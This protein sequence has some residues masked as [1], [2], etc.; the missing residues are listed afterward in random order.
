M[1]RIALVTAAAAAALTAAFALPQ[2]EAAAAAAPCFRSSQVANTRPDGDQTLYV[3]A[4]GNRYFRLDMKEPCNGLDGSLG[5]LVIEP[6]GSNLICK[7]LDAEL[8]IVSHGVSQRCRIAT[9]TPLSRDEVAALPRR[10]QP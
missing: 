9:I 8:T 3:R 2:A 5:P 6:V 4:A 7:P 10:V 1:K